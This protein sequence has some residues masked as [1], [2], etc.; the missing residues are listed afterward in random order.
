M[1]FSAQAR[2]E[3]CVWHRIRR[4][5]GLFLLVPLQQEEGGESQGACSE[6][7]EEAAAE[8]GE[9]GHGLFEEKEVEAV[10]IACTD[11]HDSLHE[12]PRHLRSGGTA[13]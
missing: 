1:P 9:A 4:Y 8:E 3:D 10:E 5:F 11:V 7:I 2:A 13:F 12:R 6:R